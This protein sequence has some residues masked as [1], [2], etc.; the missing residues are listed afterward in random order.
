MYKYYLICIQYDCICQIYDW[1]YPKYT[2]TGPKYDCFLSKIWL[3][4]IMSMSMTMM[5][6]MDGLITVLT[7][8][9]I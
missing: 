9:C 7:V 4:M 8:S 3:N 6:Q 2:W 5:D 1:I